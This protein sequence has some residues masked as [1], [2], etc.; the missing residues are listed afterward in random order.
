MFVDKNN[1]L[2]V[3][4]SQERKPE[5]KKNFYADIFQDGVFLNTIK[6][7]ITEGDDF[8]NINKQI[9]FKN[10]LIYVLDVNDTKVAVFS[11]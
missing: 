9:Y 7:D 11:Y 10:N 3:I 6:L 5:N 1:R 4:S 8:F 2:W